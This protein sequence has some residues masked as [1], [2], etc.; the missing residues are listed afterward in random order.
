ML[1]SHHVAKFDTLHDFELIFLGI[2]SDNAF[3][4]FYSEL[5]EVNA[6]FSL[7]VSCVNS[8]RWKHITDRK[9]VV[10]ETGTQR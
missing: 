1:E 6:L 9:V 4:F 2:E 5:F 7:E 3:S 10:N 8:S